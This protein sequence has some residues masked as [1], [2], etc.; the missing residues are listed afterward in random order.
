MEEFTCEDS[1]AEPPCNCEPINS[2]QEPYVYGTSLI[3]N[4]NAQLSVL[5]DLSPKVLQPDNLTV[6]LYNHQLTAVHKME[7]REINKYTY[8][9]LGIVG[10]QYRIDSNV[11]ILGDITGYGKSL[12][13]V[14]LILRD[15][16][17]WNDTGPFIHD[18]NKDF[19][20]FFGVR[21]QVKY[22]KI[23]TT[24]IVASQSLLCQW[25][26]E[27]NHSPLKILV[28][29]RKAM[30][31]KMNPRAYDVIICSH[32]MYNNVVRRFTKFAWKRF[33]FDEP[34]SIRIPKM[35]K[36]KAGFIWLLTATPSQ[37]IERCAARKDHF[38]DVLFKWCHWSRVDEVTIGIIKSLIVKNEE[39]FT[40]S[41]FRMPPTQHKHY[42]C[43]QPFYRAMYGY[44]S[45]HIL[46]CINAGNVSAAMNALGCVQTDNIV[47]Y[48]ITKKEAELKS[49]EE[50]L[51]WIRESDNSLLAREMEIENKIA[52]LTGQIQEIP[53]KFAE[54]FTDFCSICMEDL[55]DPLMIP[56]CQH[57]F[58]SKCILR[59]L[60]KNKLCPLCRTPVIK[61]SGL[62][63]IGLKDT[64]MKSEKQADRIKT[65]QE[66]VVDIIEKNP[67]GKFIIF[68][69]HCSTWGN[70]I[71][72][73]EKHGIT[74]C[75]IK[76]QMV[77]REKYKK[78]FTEGNIR[79]L[80]LTSRH[81]GS[82]MNLQETTDIIFYHK[83]SEDME[84]Q[85]IGRANRIG[86][87]KSLT[88][89]YLD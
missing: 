19:G 25:A 69:N 79:V 66:T 44:V 20:K 68:S 61:L 52:K 70:I 84:T 59:W 5:D 85:T 60:N 34:G 26:A 58:C 38:F 29:S 71:S 67:E 89:H 8:A 63:Y 14:A 24:L 11:G 77:V 76:G 64:V 50:R 88:V 21:K 4:A 6:N 55:A 17:P 33:I 16:M 82:G 80:F 43:H 45:S 51:V 12:S 39:E 57:I 9:N 3:Y 72:T 62:I 86:R 56:S 54:C 7:E 83:L 18:I 31:E 27:F 47:T 81:N 37:I 23:N 10:T 28:V 22:D 65:K 41:S 87:T 1:I 15:K 49:L 32:T 48:L 53:A 36:I 2:T 73:L 35:T 75:E 78:E 42:K 13:I 74:Y 40:K 30:A 46:E